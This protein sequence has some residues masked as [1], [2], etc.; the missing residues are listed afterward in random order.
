MRRC[1]ELRFTS[2]IGPHDL[3]VKVRERR[4]RDTARVRAFKRG[5]DMT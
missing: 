2:S 5:H 1:K 4:W 3:D